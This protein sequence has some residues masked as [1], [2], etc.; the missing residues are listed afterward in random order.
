VNLYKEDEFGIGEL[1]LR[2]GV[3]V[4]T[5]RAWE[6]RHGFPDPQRLAG[7]HRRYSE[8]DVTAIREVVRERTLGRPLGEALARARERAEAPRVSISATLQRALPDVSRV[9]LSRRALI[10][11]S[12]AIEDE[13][14]TRGERPILIGAFQRPALFTRSARRWRDLARG[15]AVAIALGGSATVGRAG[16][17]WVVPVPDASPIE[18]EWAVICDAPGL[19]ACLAGIERPAGT[20]TRRFEALWTTEPVAVRDAARTAA[21]IVVAAAPELA[22]ALRPLQQPAHA[23]RDTMRATSRLTNRIVGYLDGAGPST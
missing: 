9:V 20:G 3:G 21:A 1:A 17:L 12:H 14:S 23:T 15:S 4:S 18:R 13:V 22:A 7:G 11:M 19:T 6:R 10:A 2:T 5:L 16:S 8:R